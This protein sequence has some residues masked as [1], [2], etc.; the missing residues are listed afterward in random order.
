MTIS[1][2]I[3]TARK[4]HQCEECRNKIE[5]GEKYIRLYGMAQTPDPPYEIKL[6]MKCDHWYQDRRIEQ[7]EEKE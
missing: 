6:C 1:R 5:R 4:E 3:R 7:G 2:T